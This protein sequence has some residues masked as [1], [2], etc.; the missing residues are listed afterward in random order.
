[1][2]AMVPGAGLRWPACAPPSIVPQKPWVYMKRGGTCPTPAPL[3]PQ[4]PDLEED[5]EEEDL[6]LTCEDDEDEELGVAPRFHQGE[7]LR[8]PLALV[9]SGP[10]LSLQTR[11]RSRSISVSPPMTLAPM[12]VGVPEGGLRIRGGQPLL[13][14]LP[15]TL[16]GPCFCWTCRATRS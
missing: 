1:M 9:M 7:N 5:E 4:D 3:A 12:R 15:S 6:V 14:T 8:R 16:L 2:G 10:C 11:E 13:P